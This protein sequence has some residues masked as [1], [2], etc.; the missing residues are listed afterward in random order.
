MRGVFS[1]GRPRGEGKRCRSRVRCPTAWRARDPL[2]RRVTRPLPISGFSRLDDRLRLRLREAV[3]GPESIAQCEVHPCGTLRHACAELPAPCR[4][5]SE[6]RQERSSPLNPP[7][8]PNPRQASLRPCSRLLQNLPD[9][10]AKLLAAAMT[11]VAIRVRSW[12]DRAELAAAG[13]VQQALRNWPQTA[14]TAGAAGSA[15]LVR[16]VVAWVWYQPFAE[17]PMPEARFRRNLSAQPRLAK[18]LSAVSHAAG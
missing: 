1:A 6:P 18:G 9:P 2:P 8:Q 4:L 15:T 5:R 13:A 7:A 10:G 17:V 14:A 12:R 3:T 11:P 16:P